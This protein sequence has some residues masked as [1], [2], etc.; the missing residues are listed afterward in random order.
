MDQINPENSRKTAF[1]DQDC[2]TKPFK[3]WRRG[4]GYL[5]GV[6]TDR[7]A[8]APLDDHIAAWRTGLALLA[9]F[10]FIAM[11]ATTALVVALGDEPA[12]LVKSAAIGMLIAFSVVIFDHAMIQSHWMQAGLREARRRGFDARNPHAN[13]GVSSRVA[14][15]FTR[16]IQESG[17]GLFIILFRIALSLAIAFTVASLAILVLFEKDVSRRIEA[18]H[19]A[20]NAAIFRV[21]EANVDQEIARRTQE[22]DRLT[23]SKAEVDAAANRLASDTSTS[24]LAA[25]AARRDQLAVLERERAAALSEVMRRNADARAEEFGARDEARHSGMPGR[26]TRYAYAIAQAEIAQQRADQL[27]SEIARLSADAGGPASVREEIVKLRADS[28]ALD[29][30]TRRMVAERDARVLSREA[31]IL[32]IA[33]S[34]PGYV[35]LRDGLVRRLDAMDALTAASSSTA[36]F[37]LVMKL[38]VM[39]FEMAG[40]IAKVLVSGTSLYGVR[41]GLAFETAVSAEIRDTEDALAVDHITR[42]DCADRVGDLQD[43]RTDH[44]RRRHAAAVAQQRFDDVLHEALDR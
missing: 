40:L 30:R 24:T 31:D 19:R 13:V 2:P 22:I 42:I 35:P 10:A 20:A 1:V 44:R 33:Q 18:D 11:M 12:A 43:R 7:L 3:G 36:L 4:L 41:T 6:N 37:A 14:T 9:S 15:F 39:L 8:A 23:V 16:A 25:M 32:K 27:G 29:E 34:M 38:A 5:G 26:G 28:A 21:A 17:Q